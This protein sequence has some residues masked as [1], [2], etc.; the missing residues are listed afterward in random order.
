MTSH[1]K[2]YAILSWNDLSQ[3]EPEEADGEEEGATTGGGGAG[4]PRRLAS[5]QQVPPLAEEDPDGSLCQGVRASG[6]QDCL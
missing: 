2:D 4:R 5:R 3:V 6:G 1:G